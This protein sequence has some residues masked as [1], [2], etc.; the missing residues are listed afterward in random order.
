MYAVYKQL[1]KKL[2]NTILQTKTNQIMARR[3]TLADFGTEIVSVPDF[4]P[5]PFGMDM[6]VRGDMD[7][8][9]W[10][11]W[12]AITQTSEMKKMMNS[13]RREHGSNGLRA[14]IVDYLRENNIKLKDDI[15]DA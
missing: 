5:G 10:R 7:D 1:P 4:A 3:Q 11:R 9:E 13:H 12:N 8:R 15:E 14:A 6:V 2:I